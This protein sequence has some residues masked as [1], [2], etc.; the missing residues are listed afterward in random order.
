MPDAHVAVGAHRLVEGLPHGQMD[1]VPI[2]RVC[3]AL[4]EGLSVLDREA[5]E[6]GAFPREDRVVRRTPA[7]AMRLDRREPRVSTVPRRVVQ[8]REVIVR[9]GHVEE[10]AEGLPA[11]ARVVDEQSRG[12]DRIDDGLVV[13]LE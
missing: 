10:A 7:S 8:V 2:L 12:R 11:V 5:P 3:L 9:H 4:L 1:R 6:R 13:L